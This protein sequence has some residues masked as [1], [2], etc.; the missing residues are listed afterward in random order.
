MT[1]R[2]P[3]TTAREP[4]LARPIAPHRLRIYLAVLSFTGIVFTAMTVGVGAGWISPTFTV[5]VV[6]NLLFGIPILLVPFVFFWNAPGERRTSLEKA[7]ELT[8]LYLPY[9]ASSQLGFELPFLIGHPLGLWTTDGNP[10]WKW[11]WW[12]YALTDTRYVSSNSWIFGLEFWAVTVGI[13]FTIT[14]RQLLRKDLSDHS[15]LKWL[16]LAFFGTASLCGTVTAY[17]AS[18]FRAGFANIGQG[19]YGLWFK[20]IGENIF[21]FVLPYLA[22]YAMHLQINYLNKRIAIAGIDR[23]SG[24]SKLHMP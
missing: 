3:I 4:N 13:I 2:E 15:R 21:Y 18:E 5:D 23:P 17:Y 14:C 19:A 22:L 11:L 16:W 10:G 6:A 24:S 1:I 9:T 7:A 12:Q 20:F 8:L